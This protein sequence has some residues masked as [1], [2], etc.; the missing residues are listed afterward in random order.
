MLYLDLK[1]WEHFVKRDGN[2]LIALNEEERVY[3]E[4]HKNE[5]DR[6]LLNYPLKGTLDE[7]T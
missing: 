5:I 3:V 2:R 4:S 7:S 1:G 6:R